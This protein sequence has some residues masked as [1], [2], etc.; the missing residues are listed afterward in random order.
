MKEVNIFLGDYFKG[1]ENPASQHEQKLIFYPLISV[2]SFH[3]AKVLGDGTL[4]TCG[5][6]MST[7]LGRV[8][9]ILTSVPVSKGNYENCSVCPFFP[10]FQ[11]NEEMAPSL[12]LIQLL[13][14]VIASWVSSNERRGKAEIW[15]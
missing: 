7:F 8:A 13:F 14:C 11:R 12:F 10:R 4:V 2:L 3:S 1:Q 6:G 15:I 5:G 9:P